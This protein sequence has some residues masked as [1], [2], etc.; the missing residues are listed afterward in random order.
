M[1]DEGAASVSGA[2]E[3]IAS[4]LQ[5]IASDAAETRRL[6]NERIRRDE[7]KERAFDRLYSELEEHKRQQAVDFLKPLYLDI[8]LVI[9][10]LDRMQRAHAQQEVSLEDISAFH[11]TLRGELLEVLQRRGVEPI[12]TEREVF[13]PRLQRAIGTREVK[14]QAE[15]NQ[16]LEVVRVGYKADEQVI[17]PCE[18]IVG[19]VAQQEQEGK[20]VDTGAPGVESAPAADDAPETEGDQA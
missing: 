2:F 3:G 8:A 9:D 13:N 1:S 5:Q 7:T 20:Q 15:N 18:V 16:V 14:E 10:R 19:R 12:P 17:R 6:V 4:L 11:E